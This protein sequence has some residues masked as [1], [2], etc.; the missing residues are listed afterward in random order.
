MTNTIQQISSI[1]TDRFNYTILST[2]SKNFQP[3][4]SDYQG[5][6][7]KKWQTNTNRCYASW[8]SFRV[9]ILPLLYI[10]QFIAYIF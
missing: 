5:M 7:K 4:M 6:D 3:T 8:L 9:F 2:A 10:H 1:G